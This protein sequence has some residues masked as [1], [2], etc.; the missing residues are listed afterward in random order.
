MDEM[1][2]STSVPSITSSSVYPQDKNRSMGERR[3]QKAFLLGETLADNIREKKN[4]VKQSK[5]LRIYRKHRIG[6]NS[7]RT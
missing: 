4:Y 3:V 2:G 7:S 5:I 6:L 1:Y